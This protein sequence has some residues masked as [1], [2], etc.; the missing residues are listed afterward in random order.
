V[1]FGDAGRRLADARLARE[2]IAACGCA[3]VVWVIFLQDFGPADLSVFVRAGRAVVH[4]V[5]PYV[6]PSSPAV[7]SGHSFVYPYLVAWCFIPFAAVP[8]VTAGLVYYLGSVAALVATV[9][10]LGGPRAGAVPIVL[11]LT[12]VPVVRALQLGTLNVW[13]LF[14]LA[15]AW[16]YQSKAAVVVAALT[17]VIVA[18]LFLLP[19]LAWLVLTRRW[20]AAATTAVLCVAAVMLGFGLADQSPGSFVRM[21][22]VLSDHEAPHSSSIT[23]LVE[24]LGASRAQ[25]TGIALLAA[26][27][28]VAAGWAQARRKQ[29]EA[30][31][32]CGCVVASL[33][34]SPIVWAHYFTL[35]LLIPLTLRWQRRSQLIAW[36][37]T[38]LVWAPGG[39]PA[40]GVLHPFPGAGW[41]WGAIAVSAAL[42]WRRRRPWSESSS[43][44]LPLPKSRRVIAGPAGEVVCSVF[45]SARSAEDQRG[46][47]R[48]GD[49]REEQSRDPAGP[50]R[51]SAA[52]R[53]GMLQPADDLGDRRYGPAQDVQSGGGC[54]CEEQR[55][56]QRER[57]DALTECR[58]EHPSAGLGSQRDE[59][60]P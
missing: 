10:M 51:H 29:N 11:A 32:F 17:A 5:S 39:A 8:M 44:A 35:L 2:A 57:V 59:G 56:V 54:E 1:T 14:G 30:Y 28:V 58:E 45:P 22:S 12:A 47:D 49:E 53:A 37:V 7:W 13:L 21:L 4:G 41:L 15:I 6:D 46:G 24:L 48:R 50:A 27:V 40:L 43:G 34:A 52:S 9:R 20:R 31:I 60:Q 16:R 33:V 19:M 55:L 36:G 3:A 23:A 42:I 26:A 38:W 18:K 25:A